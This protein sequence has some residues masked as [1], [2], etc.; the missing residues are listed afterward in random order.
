MGAMLSLMA[1][2]YELLGLAFFA[3]VYILSSVLAIGLLN[4]EETSNFVKAIPIKVVVATTMATLLLVTSFITDSQ[5]E[6]KEIKNDQEIKS[7][8]NH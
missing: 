5:A 6:S 3:I 8:H 7:E 2:D 4:I 1:T